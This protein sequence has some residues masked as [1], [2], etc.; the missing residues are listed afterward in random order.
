MSDLFAQPCERPASPPDE[1]PAVCA[2]CGVKAE[3]AYDLNGWQENADGTWYC[4]EC[5]A[6]IDEEG[7]CQ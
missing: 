1:E 3:N 4:W 2:I 5:A 7:L 6:I